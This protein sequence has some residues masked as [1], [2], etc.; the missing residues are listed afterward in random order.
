V[1]SSGGRRFAAARRF[2]RATGSIVMSVTFRR[3]EDVAC[4]IG[5]ILFGLFALWVSRDYD[6]GTGSNMGPGYFPRAL[7]TI[8]IGLG[9]L[10]A[11]ANLRTPLEDFSLDDVLRMR[12]LVTIT[13]AYLVYAYSLTSI[14]LLPATL[15]LIVI[16]GLAVPRRSA[17]EWLVVV[18]LL[19]LLTFALWYVVQI[20]VPLIGGR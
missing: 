4:G 1:T 10:I 3:Y 16:S 17:M 19:E 12:P 2:P 20:S 18:V 8:I 15:L 6:V 9:A 7:S 5:L 13:A 11:L 14:G